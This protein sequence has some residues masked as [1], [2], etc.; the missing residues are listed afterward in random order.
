MVIDNS[1]HERFIVKKILFLALLTLGFVTIVSAQVSRLG[2]NQR[3][4]PPAEAAA[5]SGN[6]VVAHGMPAIRSGGT[7]Y[8]V[9]G[10]SRLTGF[11]DGLKEG[12]HVTI[13]G[14]SLVSQRDS[15]IKFLR[16][17]TMTLDG[18]NYDLSFPQEFTRLRDQNIPR[19]SL[20]NH[21][22]RFPQGR[23]QRRAL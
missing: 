1:F 7:T 18:R 23:P 20:R 8:L 5:V 9:F 16:P 6:L 12:A 10:I 15:N 11:V 19:E 2:W 22:H 3:G 17:T 4:L 14:M 13:E 21:G